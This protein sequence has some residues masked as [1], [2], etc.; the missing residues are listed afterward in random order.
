MSRFRLVCIE[1]AG[2]D[3]VKFAI[4]AFINKYAII[5]SCFLF[6]YESD[7]KKKKMN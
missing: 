3:E 7:T 6:V 5:I 2:I 1:E 4:C